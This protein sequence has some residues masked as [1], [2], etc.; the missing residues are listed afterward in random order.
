MGIS[1]AQVR[2][3]RQTEVDEEGEPTVNGAVALPVIQELKKLDRK[4]GKKRKKRKT[5]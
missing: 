3:F 1:F 2:G 5:N 4:R